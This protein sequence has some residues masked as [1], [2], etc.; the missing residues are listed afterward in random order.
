M[1]DRQLGARLR[2][3]GRA[4]SPREKALYASAEPRPFRSSPWLLP[5]LL[6]AAAGREVLTCCAQFPT[7]WRIPFNF[8]HLSHP[9]H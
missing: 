4:A 5:A 6:L 9:V 1:T 7:Q 3:L 2:G 8:A